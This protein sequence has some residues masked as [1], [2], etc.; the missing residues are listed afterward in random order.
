LEHLAASIERAVEGVL[1][2]G[3]RTKDVAAAGCRIVSTRE[4]TERIVQ[5]LEEQPAPQVLKA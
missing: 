3:W 4:M 5:A 1:T 2:N